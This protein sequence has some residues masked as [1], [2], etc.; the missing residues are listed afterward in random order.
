MDTIVR[1][2]EKCTG[3]TACMNSCPVGAIHMT[4]D[5]AGFYYPTVDENSCIECGKCLT[6]CPVE[7][8]RKATD[9]RVRAY[10]GAS[11]DPELVKCSSSGGAFSLMAMYVLSQ[12]GLVCGAVMDYET[13]EIV[14]ADTDQCE[15]DALRR[16]KYVASFPKD[17]FC[18]IKRELENGRTVL[19]CG[20]PCH[21]DGLRCFLKKDYEKLI[22][23]DF[24]CGG[25]ASPRFFREHLQHLEKKYRSEVADVNF[26]AKLNGWKEHSLKISFRN[27]KEYRSVAFFDSFFK[28]YFEKPF[29]RNSCYACRYRLGH[30]SDIIVADYWGG[31]KKGRGNNQG[32]SM[33]ITNSKKGDTFF[34]DVLLKGNHTFTEMPL[35]DSDY[36]FKTEEQR[37]TKA[38]V[39]KDNFMKL[40]GKKG[41][42]KAA[43][44][45]YFRKITMQ[46]LKRNLVAV[47]KRNQ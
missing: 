41:F 1:I 24:I 4:E 47:L 14:Y 19:F 21:V 6:V 45:T 2:G 25:T 29:Q 12:Q 26:R 9:T 36:V 32:V 28:G 23:C 13:R 11:D 31:L 3:C 7:T 30:A 43:R 44:A 5:Q 33:V 8:T 35:A 18:N 22:L 10:Y 40:Y 17:I 37:Y 42:E 46:K 34:T 20:L 15:L 16:S 27:G 38:R 39:A